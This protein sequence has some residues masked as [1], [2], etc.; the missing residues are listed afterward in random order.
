MKTDHSIKLRYV[1]RIGRVVCEN[2]MKSRFRFKLEKFYHHRYF[3]VGVCILFLEPSDFPARIGFCSQV[4]IFHDLAHPTFANVLAIMLR[5]S[6]S[7]LLFF[8]FFLTHQLLSV[9]PVLDLFLRLSRHAPAIATF[10][11]TN[12]LVYFGR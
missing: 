8:D 4:A 3:A 5:Y 12:I 1:I 7:F 2:L 6:T 9:V 10:A 11:L